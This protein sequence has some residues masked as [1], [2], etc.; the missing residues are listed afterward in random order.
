MEKQ[1]KYEDVNKT[2]LIEFPAFTINE[3]DFELPYIVAGCFTKFILAAYQ[4]GDKETYE[5]GLRF[6]EILH[7]DTTHKVRELATIGYLESIQNKWSQDLIN[8]NIPFNDLG[9]NSKRWWI[10]LNAFWNG[11]ITALKENDSIN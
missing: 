2:L 10:K 4:T 8:S 11:D 6:I 7:S 9:E 1:M 5:K 3:D